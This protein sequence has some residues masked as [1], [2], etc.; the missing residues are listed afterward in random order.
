MRLCRRAELR[1]RRLVLRAELRLLRL[2][3]RLLRPQVLLVRQAEG[4][5]G[6]SQGLL[7]L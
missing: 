2:V 1:L 7:L 4:P 3:L 6:C 5:S